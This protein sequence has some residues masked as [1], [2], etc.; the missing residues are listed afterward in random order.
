MKYHQQFCQTYSDQYHCLWLEI[1]ATLC[2]HASIANISTAVNWKHWS[3]AER[4]QSPIINTLL[5][6]CMTQDGEW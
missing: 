5:R 6:K 3:C 1:Q 2:Q 4:P